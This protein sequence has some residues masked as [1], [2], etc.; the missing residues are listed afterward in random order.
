MTDFISNKTSIANVFNENIER[1]I[2]QIIHFYISIIYI[3]IGWGFGSNGRWCVSVAGV[4]VAVC[5]TDRS[6]TISKY[7]D[8]VAPV[9]GRISARG[10]TE[11]IILEEQR[12]VSVTILSCH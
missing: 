10:V 7:Q 4:S 11:S 1:F 6:T 9:P 2:I 8:Q 3:Y 12:C 5:H